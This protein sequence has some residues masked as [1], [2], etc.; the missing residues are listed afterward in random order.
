MSSQQIFNE[1]PDLLTQDLI[2]MSKAGKKFP[3]PVG[4]ST[5]ERWARIG[6]TC[7]GYRVRLE[8]V[9]IGGKRFTSTEAIIRFLVAQQLSQGSQT[10]ASNP[11]S[12]MSKAEIEAG[13]KRFN[14]PT[15]LEN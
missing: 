9:R 10:A 11:K 4:R 2:P 3:V 12:S 6:V 14:L 15:P 5:V 1:N 13:R 8:T 7:G